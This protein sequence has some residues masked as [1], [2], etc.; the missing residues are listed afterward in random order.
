MRRVNNKDRKKKSKHRVLESVHNR[1]SFAFNDISNYLKL[2][3]CCSGA[4]AETFINLFGNNRQE[5]R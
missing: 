4:D 5:W 1:N 2:F 3:C